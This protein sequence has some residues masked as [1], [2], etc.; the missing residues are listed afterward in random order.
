MNHYRMKEGEVV[1][2]PSP[3]GECIAYPV[4]QADGS[5]SLCVI[6]GGAFHNFCISRCCLA[7][8]VAEGGEIFWQEERLAFRNL[9]K[10]DGDEARIA[11][12]CAASATRHSTLLP[13]WRAVFWFLV[14]ALLLHL[15]IATPQH[16]FGF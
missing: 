7:R 6:E 5:Y 13:P 3:A 15:I 16:D 10:A 11:G 1:M 9:H 8:L 14:F 12:C 4:R 2:A